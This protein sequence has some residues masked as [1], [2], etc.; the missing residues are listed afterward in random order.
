LIIENR[1]Q[2]YHDK[3]MPL[4]DYY[5]AQQKCHKIYG[6]GSVDEI[7]ERLIETVSEL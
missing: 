4:K 5:E 6:I 3:T 2:V 1:I 7:A